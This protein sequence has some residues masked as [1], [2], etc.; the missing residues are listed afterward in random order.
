MILR[1]ASVALAGLALAGCAAPATPAPL[2]S[3][4]P[5]PHGDTA[6]T[7]AHRPRATPHVG[8]LVATGHGWDNTGLYGPTFAAGACHTSGELPDPHCTPGAVDAAV[9]QS[10]LA[11]TICRPGYTADVRPPTRLTNRGKT[12]SKLEYGVTGVSEYDHLVPL[13]LGG[14]SDT[15]NLWAETGSI[16]NAKDRIENAL[17]AAVCSGRVTLEAAQTAIAANWTTAA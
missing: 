9:T 16:P 4:P 3:P 13:E 14:A 12:Q 11:T 8:L 17:H 15:R 2:F 6:T 1:S 10:N 5:A 7:K